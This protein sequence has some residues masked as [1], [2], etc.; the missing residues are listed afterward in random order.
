MTNC[1]NSISDDTALFKLGR[2]KGLTSEL[3]HKCTTFFMQC[4]IIMR[5]DFFFRDTEVHEGITIIYGDCG[6]VI[7]MIVIFAL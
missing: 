5:Y 3:L 7:I 2:N 1:L 6:M 4:L